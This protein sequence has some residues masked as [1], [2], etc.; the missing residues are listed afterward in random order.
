MHTPMRMCVGCRRMK[1]K[2]ELIRIVRGVNGEPVADE[3]QKILSRG[4]YICKDEKCINTAR[5]RKA[6]ERF[7]KNGSYDKLYDSLISSVGETK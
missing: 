1:P 5:K 4:I 6:F 3:K 2:G 7:F